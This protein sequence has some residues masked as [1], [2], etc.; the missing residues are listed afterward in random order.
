MIRLS[1]M[2]DYAVV[3]MG[4]MLYADPATLSANQVADQS[5]I[6]LPTVSKVLKYLLK[7]GLLESTRGLHGG[8]R[9]LR[10]AEQISIAEIIEAVD[11][12]IA[13]TDCATL[14]KSCD[15]A[16]QNRCPTEK[17]WNKLNKKIHQAFASVTLAEIVDLS[18]KETQAA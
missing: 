9:L 7:A 5:G 16:I 4:R 1:K 13:L 3:L 8:Y 14:S 15:C 10:P 17:G 18:T 12:P 6:P 11:G 2:A